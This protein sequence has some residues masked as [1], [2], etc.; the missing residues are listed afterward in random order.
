M[1][2]SIF[3]LIVILPL[4]LA[5]A[6]LAAVLLIALGTIPGLYYGCAYI[7]RVIYNIASK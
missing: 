5:L 7:I 6:A 3:G 4:Y 1:I 2:C